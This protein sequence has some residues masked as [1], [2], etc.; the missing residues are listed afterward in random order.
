M[1]LSDIA[2][3]AL[4]ALCIPL[5]IPGRWRAWAMCAV[6][7]VAIFWLQP[8]LPVRWLDYTLSAVTLALVVIVW[9]LTQK[10]A[11]PDQQSTIWQRHDYAALVLAVVITGVLA[12]AR[13]VPFIQGWQIT[14][15]PPE[16]RFVLMGIGVFLC[17]LLLMSGRARSIVPL[18]VLSGRRIG[19]WIAIFG[20]IVLLII[21]KTEPF[22]ASVAAGWRTL[23]G[24]D[25]SLASGIDVR[26]LGFSYVAF[27]LIH[28]L[29]DAQ[30]G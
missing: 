23:S 13:D 27:R 9:R 15:R 24:Q 19:V 25:V 7:I 11:A 28:M 30:L 14:T 3:F 16:L 10:R 22:A 20:I 1:A 5:L 26:W 18:R 17:L 8:P 6:S 29:R 4:I 21:L 2:L 12:L